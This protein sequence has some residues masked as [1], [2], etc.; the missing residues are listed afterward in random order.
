MDVRCH[1]RWISSCVVQSGRKLEAVARMTSINH[2]HGENTLRRQR[3]RQT[4]SEVKRCERVH[5]QEPVL[6]VWPRLMQLAGAQSKG[7]VSGEGLMNAVRTPSISAARLPGGDESI[8]S[9]WC[10]TAGPGPDR[11]SC[12]YLSETFSLFSLLPPADTPPA[13]HLKWRNQVKC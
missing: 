6:G 7:P 5:S 2:C 12:F 4:C 1:L 9:R 10:F 3:K 8:S 13:L 11:C